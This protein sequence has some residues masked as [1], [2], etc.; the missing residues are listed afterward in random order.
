MG[1]FDLLPPLAPDRRGREPDANAWIELHNLVVAA[2]RLDELGD[3]HLDRIQRQRGVDLRDA[4]YDQRVDFYERYLDWSLEDNDFS[5][6]N[7]ALLGVLAPTLGLT[8]GDLRDSHRRAFGNIVH[9]ALAD[10]CLSVD[11]RLLLYKLQ[12]TLGLDPDLADGAFEVMARQ[13]LLV[14]VARVLCDGELSPEEAAEVQKA[15]ADLGVTVPDRVRHM[16]DAAAV[17][18]RSRHT[19]DVPMSSRETAQTVVPGLWR[20]V[21]LSQVRKVFGDPESREALASGDTFH[22]R[23]PAVALRGPRREG[24]VVVTSR[25]LLLDARGPEAKAYTHHAIRRVLRFSN[26]VLIELKGSRGVFVESEDDPR[27]ADAL[28]AHV[29]GSA[30]GR[31]QA[32]VAEQTWTARWSPLYAP[33]RD[34]M[35]RKVG[36]SLAKADRWEQALKH[37][38]SA[39]RWSGLGTIRYAG[40]SV[41]MQ[42]KGARLN[43]SLDNLR[44]VHTR[45]RLVWLDRRK[46]HDWVIEFLTTDEADAFTREVL[47]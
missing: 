28:A 29:R 43:T 34:R 41:R 17:R 6:G 16:L 45:G 18:W 20:E 11:E 26:G 38:G 15:Q 31:A 25:R 8:S 47:R 24:K 32:S 35:L 27:L 46:G 39:A 4:F 14:T 22:Y 33:D 1:P 40:R 13:R 10:D 5:D 44:G 42:D 21:N 36:G 2:E 12:H 23:L 30:S 19:T 3:H 7:R 9:E 37:F